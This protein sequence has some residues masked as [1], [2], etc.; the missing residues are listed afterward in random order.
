[1]NVDAMAYKAS[2]DES[3][4]PATYQGLCSLIH[5]HSRIHLGEGRQCLLSSRLNSRRNHLGL[6]S[7]DAYYAYLT[8]AENRD[9]ISMLID[10]ISTNHTSFFREKT[11]FERLRATLLEGIFAD[12]EG[13]S[14][15][16][17]AWSAAS[18]TGEEP[19]SL[20]IM[21]NEH[22]S[23]RGG[24]QPDWIVHASDISQKALKTAES[25]I[26]PKEDLNLPKPEWQQRY[27]KRGSGPY[28]GYCR[29]KPEITKRVKFQKI[30]L[31]QTPY[32]IPKPVHLIFCRN[33]LI[34]FEQESQAQVVSRLFHMLNPGGILVVGHSDSLSCFRHEFE[35]LGG[36]IFRRS[37]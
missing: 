21:I 22:L 13:A 27:F 34:Y 35:T 31:F 25:A 17:T 28:E 29:L 26:Y 10:L 11:H 3:M 18:S 36:G 5:K 12:C 8:K 37:L 14:K 2:V 19:Y 9:E 33:V 24:S 30:N 32:P 6:K 23:Q 15:R 16:L 20:A 4:S 1:M 7:W